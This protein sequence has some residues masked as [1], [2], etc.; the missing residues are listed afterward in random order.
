MFNKFPI[1]MGLIANSSFV[2]PTNT[3][4]VYPINP[5]HYSNRHYN[6]N[7]YGC[8]C[9][10]HRYNSNTAVASEDSR[11]YLQMSPCNQAASRAHNHL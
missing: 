1:R 8:E 9:D 6:D 3:N 5:S 7:Q 11:A 4:T 10:S 2:I